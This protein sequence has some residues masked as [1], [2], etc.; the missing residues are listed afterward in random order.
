MTF[1]ANATEQLIQEVTRA[2][3]DQVGAAPILSRQPVINGWCCLDCGG[4]CVQ[5]FPDRAN[6]IIQ[7]GATR[8]SAHL[9]ANNIAANLARY[10]DH[11]LLKPDATSEQIAQLCQ[12]ARKFR[13]ASVC[14]NPTYVKLAAQ[15]LQGSP[16]EVCTVIGF[17]LG[18][19]TSAVKSYETQ[20]ALYDGAT[21]VD[22]VMNVGALKS[23]DYELVQ[24]DIAAVSQVAHSRNAVCKVILE[25]ALLTDEEKDKASRLAKAGGADF[26]KTSTG[27]GGGGATT[28]DVALMRQAVGPIIG[29]KASGGIKSF[30][31]AEEMITAGATRIGASA[32]VQIMQEARG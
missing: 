29:V 5:Q 24:R 9:G 20:R 1:S 14:I 16:V 31:D 19:N 18:A 7:A 25:T 32:G 3:V 23:G 10:I 13:F 8:L 28:H 6:A 11:T 12:E 17:P 15:L 27:F 2:I 26:V 22:M 21:E 30:T 4:Q